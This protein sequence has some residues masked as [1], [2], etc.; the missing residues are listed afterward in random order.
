M[1]VE[2]ECGLDPQPLDHS[3]RCG[4]GVG[5]RFVLVGVDDL[6]LALSSSSTV[7]LST[8]QQR[9][10][11]HDRARPYPSLTR[12]SACASATTKLVVVTAS[13]VSRIF[14]RRATAFS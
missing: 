4:I 2:G 9:L 3:E 11:S 1:L 6:S 5:E 10:P 12:M 7:T 14:F 13:P 8:G